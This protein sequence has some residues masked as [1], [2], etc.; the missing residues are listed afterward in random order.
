MKNITEKFPLEVYKRM[1]ARS[2]NKIMDSERGQ[3]LLSKASKFNIPFDREDIDWLKLIG[4]VEEYEALLCEAEDMN[5]NW[6]DS[7]YEPIFL[8]QEIE[9]SRHEHSES[10]REMLSDFHATT[11]VY[12]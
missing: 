2:H 9:Q 8:L 6:D 4:D 3:N 5:I 7:Q 10:R 11:G 12:I 1:C